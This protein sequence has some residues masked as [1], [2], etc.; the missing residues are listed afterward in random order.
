MDINIKALEVTADTAKEFIQKLLF[1]AIEEVGGL[2]AD[3]LKLFR[4]KNQVDVLNR[5]ENI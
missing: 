3:R 5:A 4:L 1:P 2:L